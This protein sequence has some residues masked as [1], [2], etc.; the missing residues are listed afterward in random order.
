MILRERCLFCLTTCETTLALCDKCVAYLPWQQKTCLQCGSSLENTVAQC[1]VCLATPPHFDSTISLFQYAT[2]ISQMIHQLKFR[3]NLRMAQLF[4]KL[5]ILY[6][7][8]NK[9]VLP[10]VIIPVPLHFKRLKER[11]FNQAIEIAKPINKH[12]NIPIDKKSCI[13]IKNTVAQSTLSAKKRKGNLRNAFGLTWPLNLKHVAILDDVMTTGSTINEIAGLL[14]TQGVEK[15]EAWCCAKVS[16]FR[17][18]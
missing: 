8:K 17:P 10:D 3:S 6:L 9:I 12:L 1:G 15:I 2:P 7:T 11:G 18:H 14:K 13:R 4:G 5:W 16:I